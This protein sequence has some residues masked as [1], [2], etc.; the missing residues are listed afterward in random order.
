MKKRKKKCKMTEDLYTF[1]HGFDFD[2]LA[3]GAWQALL[4]DAV[5]FYND[6][7]STNFDPH[8]A[9]LAYC[10]RQSAF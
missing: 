9:F 8:D 4:M 5:T 2:D 1:M 10:A 6:K 7:N 3:D